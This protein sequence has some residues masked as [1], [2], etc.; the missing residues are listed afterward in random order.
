MA[1]ALT[2]AGAAFAQSN[3]NIV[4]PVS[5]QQKIHLQGGPGI[6]ISGSQ[7]KENL[8]KDARD[9]LDKFYKDITV[10]LCRED[11]IKNT[12]HVM[13]GDNTDIVFNKD[14]KVRD[15]K[16]GYNSSIPED[17]LKAI[18]PD[19]TVKHLEQAGVVDEVSA[20]KDAGK[21]GFGVALLNNIPP[22]MIFDADGVFIF[23]AG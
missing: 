23:T 3:N 21:N 8:P 14:G 13:L 19:R 7:Q 16:A 5:V 20:I 15:I 17:E 22:Q 2:I 18:L 10:E 1:A 6:V 11:F 4:P 9:F 12:Y